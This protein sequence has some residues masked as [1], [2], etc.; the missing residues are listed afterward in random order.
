MTLIYEQLKNKIMKDYSEQIEQLRKEITGAIIGL[1]RTHGLTEIVFPDP[2]AAAD[3]PDS[4][5]VIF[6]DDDG[7]PFECA[8]EKVKIDGDSL[9]ITASEKHG[10]F[11]CSSESSFDLSLRSPIWLNEILI[12][13]Q[14]LLEN[15]NINPQNT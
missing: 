5:F 10:L 11:R 14:T 7:E 9:S 1:L 12:A 8:V 15:E 3:A 13:A 4:V 2:L 6:F